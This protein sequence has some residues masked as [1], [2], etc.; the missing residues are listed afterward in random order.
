MNQPVL[1][2]VDD[3]F[4]VSKITETARQ[5]GISLLFART[6]DEVIARALSEKPALLIIDLNSARCNP[7][8]TIGQIKED[9]DLRH[10]PIVGFLSHVQADLKVKASM[11]GCDRVM[12]RSVFTAQ[13]PKI[14]SE[15]TASSSR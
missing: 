2:A 13:L 10:I 9:A 11:A 15:Y 1:V 8:E 12:P 14:L 6:Q 3:L 4:F 5:L 7:I